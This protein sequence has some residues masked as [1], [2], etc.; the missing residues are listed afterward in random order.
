MPE[1]LSGTRLVD[2][3]IALSVLEGLALALYHRATSRGIPPGDYALN[4]LSGLCLM[5]AVRSQLAGENLLWLAAWLL[6]AGVA[7]WADIWRRWRRRA[8]RPS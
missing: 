2:L 1:F 3:V 4:L 8:L 6:A 5:L 7:H